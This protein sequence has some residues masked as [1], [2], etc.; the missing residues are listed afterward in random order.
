MNDKTYVNN[1]PD[2]DS[3]CNCKYTPQLIICYTLND[4]FGIKSS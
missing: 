4:Y 2:L 3:N 1:I